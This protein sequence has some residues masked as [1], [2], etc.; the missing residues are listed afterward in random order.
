M[1]STLPNNSY[2]T[3][4]FCDQICLVR[5]GAWAS[6]KLTQKL[7]KQISLP[8][9]QMEYTDPWENKYTFFWREKKILFLDS[10]DNIIFHKAGYLTT[11]GNISLT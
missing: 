5:P 1:L 8:I 10:Q 9:Y 3:G 4:P 11:Q 2:K 6:T 7:L